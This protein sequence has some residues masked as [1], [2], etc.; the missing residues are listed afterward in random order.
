MSIRDVG[1]TRCDGADGARADA[2]SGRIGEQVLN[3]ERIL[4]KPRMKKIF[5]GADPGFRPPRR[6][7][8]G[9]AMV[10]RGV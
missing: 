1:V 6:R 10:S 8:F 3:P 2:A 5:C 9:E 7:S 4:E